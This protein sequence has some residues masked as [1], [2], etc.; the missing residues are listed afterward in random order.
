MTS[1]VGPA[2]L[3]HLFDVST[4]VQISN[5]PANTSPEAHA[6]HAITMV[7]ADCVHNTVVVCIG[8]SLQVCDPPEAQARLLAGSQQHNGFR[9]DLRADARLSTV[10]GVAVDR[11]K[12]VIFTDW[13]NNCIREIGASG[14]VRTVYGAQP[15]LPHLHGVSGFRDG[16]AVEARFSRP[17][18]LCL[19]NEDREIIVVDGNNS[20]IRRIDRCCG[21]VTTMHIVQDMSIDV[22]TGV[23]PRPTQLFYPSTVRLSKSGCASEDSHIYVVSGSCL[24]VFRIHLATGVFQA[25]PCMHN[26]HV[27]YRPV[28]FDITPKRQLILG[29]TGYDLDRARND[30]KGVW[31]GDIKLFST[32]RSV[33]YYMSHSKIE[34]CACLCIS[35]GIDARTSAATLWISDAQAESRLL[36]VRLRLKWSFLRVLQLAVRK[37][38]HNT[39]FALLP[40]NTY[41]SHTHCP[42][43]DHIVTLLEGVVA[44]A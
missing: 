5:K 33:I 11:N 10:H 7:Y 2:L 13:M 23:V 28:C 37:P 15:V 32:N 8:S 16:C 4:T 38:S 26:P 31:L 19:Y 6:K 27:A 20:S 40:T 14:H 18:G 43:L 42:L 44:F 9:D 29:Y 25:I 12:I 41:N 3:S 30:I 34:I 22:S 17:W 24:E 1:A 39:L 21:L 35:L 36:R